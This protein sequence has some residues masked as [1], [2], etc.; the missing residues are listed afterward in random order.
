MIVDS[1]NNTNY[2][3]S[4]SSTTS[5]IKIDNHKTKRGNSWRI[6]YSTKFKAS[7][8]K[9]YKNESNRLKQI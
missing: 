7:I 2:V 5:C 1:S 4:S 8:I 3:L 6:Q 9:F